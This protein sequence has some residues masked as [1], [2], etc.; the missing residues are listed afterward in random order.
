VQTIQTLNELFILSQIAGGT[1]A[2]DFSIMEALYARGFT[3]R[4]DVLGHPF[5]NFRQALTGTVAYDHAAAIYANAGAPP[6]FPLPGTSPFGPVNPGCLT[7]CI[8]APELLPARAGG[9]PERDAARLRA[10]HVR[11]SVRRAVRRAY[12]SAGR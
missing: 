2:L 6:V 12:Q 11:R 10:V 3:S 4:D 5:D 9:S 1:P 8:P 7:D